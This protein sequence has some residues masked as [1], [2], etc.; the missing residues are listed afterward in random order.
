MYLQWGG[1]HGALQCGG[2]GVHVQEV[3]RV[4]VLVLWVHNRVPFGRFIG[5]GRNGRHFGD[6]S[7]SCQGAL[8]WDGD[9]QA[10]VVEGGERPDDTD[11]PMAAVS[12]CV[13]PIFSVSRGVVS[14]RQGKA[15]TMMAIGWALSL[16]PAMNVFSFSWTIVWFLI[17]CWNW[18]YWN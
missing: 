4:A 2:V 5:H 11:L 1:V 18:L 14:A 12:P 17:V 15:G 16:K 9:V 3:L 7:D 13:I 6:E 10:V 8:L